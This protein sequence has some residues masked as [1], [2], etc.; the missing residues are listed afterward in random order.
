V[1]A[2]IQRL[3]LTQENCSAWAAAA[4]AAKWPAHPAAGP[5]QVKKM[6]AVIEARGLAKAY[7][8]TRALDGVNFSV[9]PGRIAVSSSLTDPNG[10][11]KTTP[12]RRSSDSPL[13]GELTV[14]GLDPRTQRDALDARGVASWPTW[15]CCRAGCA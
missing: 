12:S 9:E 8:A 4:P 1:Y 15:P 2:T 10:A 3:G 14:L 6:T 5:H 13:R 7:G 11:G